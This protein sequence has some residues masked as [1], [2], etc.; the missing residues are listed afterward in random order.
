[1]LLCTHGRMGSIWVLFGLCV[2][3]EG[4]LLGLLVGSLWVG[5]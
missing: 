5:G 1:M 4:V 3:E 2:S